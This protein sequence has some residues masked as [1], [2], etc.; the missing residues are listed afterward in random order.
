MTAEP[1][2]TPADN[3]ERVLIVKYGKSRE[4]RASYGGE[5]EHRAKRQRF[6]ESPGLAAGA[7]ESTLGLIATASKDDAEAAEEQ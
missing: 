7:S 6:E 3:E 4:R 5:G 1:L 2:V